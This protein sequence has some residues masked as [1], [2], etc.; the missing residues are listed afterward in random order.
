MTAATVASLVVAGIA[1]ISTLSSSALN[2]IDLWCDM[3]GNSTFQ[4]R[5]TAMNWTSMIP[6]GFYSVGAMKKDR[7]RVIRQNPG[8]TG[9]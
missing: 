2:I 3:S 5:K 9:I 1:N 7:I 4:A 6:S 8:E